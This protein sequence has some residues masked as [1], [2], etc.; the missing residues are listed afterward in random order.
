MAIP[1]HYRNAKINKNRRSTLKERFKR[2][3]NNADMPGNQKVFLTQNLMGIMQEYAE[4][5]ECRKESG[6]E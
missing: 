4:L 6:V 2:I 5:W 1:Y 3:I